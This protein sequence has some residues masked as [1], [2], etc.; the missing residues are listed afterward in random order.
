MGW[1]SDYRDDVGRYTEYG[2]SALRMVLT[3]QGLWALLQYRIAHAIYASSAPRPLK[4]VALG[5]CSMWRKVIEMTAGI[6][7]PHDASIAPGLYIGHFGGVIVSSG[8]VIGPGCNISQ[9]VTLGVSGRG[10][11][12]GTPTLGA[13]VYIAANAVV[14]GKIHVGEGA[15]ISACS[16]V[17]RDVPAGALVSGVPASIV[18]RDEDCTQVEDT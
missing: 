11:R 14:A 5:L 6:Q 18:V 9:G 4:V 15:R 10:V 16:L 7:L 13:G 12:R 1:L 2:G 3:A 17:I 8:S